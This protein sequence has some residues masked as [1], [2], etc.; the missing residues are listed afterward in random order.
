MTPQSQLDE[1]KK[2]ESVARNS[3]GEGRQKNDEL[4]KPTRRKTQRGP[5]PREKGKKTTHRLRTWRHGAQ[6]W[7]LKRQERQPAPLEKTGE[8]GIDPGLLAERTKKAGVADGEEGPEFIAGV[9]MLVKK[10]K[11]NGGL[12]EPPLK[13]L[14]DLHNNGRKEGD[15][16]KPSGLEGDLLFFRE[17][18]NKNRRYRKGRKGKGRRPPFPP[19]GF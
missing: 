18:K 1:E 13:G 14:R 19:C 7:S 9:V 6:L 2:G 12:R 5:S 3:P 17:G 16:S 15:P 11:K 4:L 8:G 10:E